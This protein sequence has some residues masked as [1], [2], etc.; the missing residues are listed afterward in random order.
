MSANERRWPARAAFVLAYL[1]LLASFETGPSSDP[2]IISLGIPSTFTLPARVVLGI[3]FFAATFMGFR[4]SA[5]RRSWAALAAPLTLALTQFLWFVLP[6]LL[7]LHAA[8][9]IPQTRYSSGILA[10]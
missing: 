5:L 7:E 1:V 3:V 4:R 9:Q 10:Q 8:Y 6:T 2:L